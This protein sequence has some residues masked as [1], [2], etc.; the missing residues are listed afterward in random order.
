MKL[1]HALFFAEENEN[2]KTM[3]RNLMHSYVVS[4]ILAEDMVLARPWYSYKV[5]LLSENRHFSWILHDVFANR[6]STFTENKHSS[7]FCAPNENDV[8]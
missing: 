6:A 4:Y 8:V 7:V 3:L 2:D 5:N 1:Y